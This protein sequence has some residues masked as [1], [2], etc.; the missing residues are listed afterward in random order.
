MPDYFDRLLARHAPAPVAA[1]PA[2]GPDG[3]DGPARVRPRLPGPFERI[4]AL[5]AEPPLPDEPAPLLVGADQPGVRQDGLIRHEREIR[6]DRHTVVRTEPAP[7]GEPDAPADPPPTAP[8]LRPATQLTPGPRP[9]APDTARPERRAAS[10]AGPDAPQRTAVPARVPSGAAARPAA[11]ASLLPRAADSG[12]DRAARSA[13]AT[14][15]RPRT[16]ERVVH[17]QIG[18][19]EVSA[20]GTSGPGRTA[21]RPERAGRSAPTLSLDDY[22]SRGEKRD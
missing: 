19:L 4:E 22:L 17:V 20:A 18:R 15:R 10:P 5:R 21:A 2:D 13:A 12:T 16:A 6:T 8:L 14:R 11:A 9:V 1:R 3:P 7:H